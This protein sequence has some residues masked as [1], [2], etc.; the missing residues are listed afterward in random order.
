[1]LAP[2]TPAPPQARHANRPP[3]PR[4][5]SY[6]KRSKD[7]RRAFESFTRSF[8]KQRATL[9]MVFL[10][11]DASIPPQQA[12]VEYASWLASAGVPFSIVFTKADKRKKGAPRAGENVA[13]FKRALL[14]GGFPFVPPSV[15]TSAA[16]GGGKTELLALIASLRVMW[17]GARRR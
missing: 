1:V 16:S 4:A 12:D 9:A 10:L 8:L 7:Q 5:R 15:V 3:P 13:A 17:E 11:V 2:R 14:G 6:A